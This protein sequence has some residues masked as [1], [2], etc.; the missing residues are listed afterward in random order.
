VLVLIGAAGA[1]ALLWWFFFGPKRSST[2]EL[3]GGVQEIH[4]TVKGGYSP[5]R[6]RARRGVPLRVIFDRQ[7]TGDCTARVV[8]PD[9]AMSRSLPAYA[10]TAVELTPDRV[11]EFGFACG[12]NMVHGTLV[13][14][15]TDH[16]PE[17][18]G[19]GAGSNGAHDE[20]APTPD[21]VE[22]PDAVTARGAHEI[23]DAEAAARR[24]EIADLSRRVLV[25][26]LLTAP[27]AFAAM[28]HDLFGATWVPD[29]LLDRWVQL[30]LIT[31]VMLYT[32]WPIHHIGWLT[33]RHRTAEMNTLITLGT[34]AAYSY[35]LLVTIAPSV[36]PGDVREVY[37]ETVGV[38]L[39]LI[40]LGRL[41]ETRAK[42]GTGEAIR[43]LIGLQART[44]RVIRDNVEV[45][46]PIDEVAG[47][48]VVV[49]RPGEKIPV[50]GTVIDGTSTVDESMVTG[51]PIPVT[52]RTDDTVIGATI[53]QTGAFRMRA[54]KVGAET[55][56][57]QIIKLV[58]AA[59][60]SKAPIQ[61]LADRV[62]SYF[63]PAVMVIAVWTFAIWYLTGPDPVL[64]L[65]LVTAVAVLIIACPC[66][67]G[68]ATPLSIMVGTGIGATQGILIRSAEALETAEKLDTLIL[69]KTGTITRGQPALTDVI[70]DGF[71]E[72]ELLELVASAEHSSEHPLAEAIV[73]GA[74]A[75]GLELTDPS[76]FQ[77]VTGQGISGRVQGR[78]VLI[79]NRRLLETEGIPANALEPHAERLANEGKTPMLV[80][81]DGTAAGVIAVADTLK[82]DSVLAIRA[83]QDLNL[84]VVMIT[85][86]NRRTAAAIAK[87]VGITRV[88]AE[89]L[90]E[91]KALEVRRLQGEGRTVGMVG[92]GINDAPALAQ[93]DVGAA[94][95]TGT[96]VAI[97]SSDV[98]LV[99]GALGGLVTAI[100]LSRATMRNI[101][102]N[103]FLAFVYNTIGIPLAAGALYPLFEL[104][105]SPI[106]AATAMALSSLSVVTNANRLHRFTPTTPSSSA[107]PHP[108]DPLV[109]VSDT[110]ETDMATTDPV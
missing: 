68:L 20:R 55:L 14:E 104:R 21:A 100:Q 5:D 16:G 78:A 8:F 50:D 64:T 63:V 62:S 87:Q 56:L 45:E 106:V 24:A 89:V 103:L 84:D 75:R 31:P 74:R 97:E 101:R 67:L 82:D 57:A 80:A 77:S 90:P 76:E 27:V 25:G 18:G 11:G 73:A 46:I 72:P 51:E 86:D 49:V 9:F 59:Q 65:S 91:H 83:L 79:G 85:G 22:H 58:E 61:R 13:I 23:E 36:F 66:A 108:V 69:D 93:A 88:L 33:L 30:A 47:G 32:G 15:D 35:S 52:K 102:Q 99:S 17:R 48:D 4:V 34:V 40:L 53:N 71:D 19:V 29:V 81:I 110:I 105:L 41:F 6:I 12:M 38:I 70:A 98:T 43:K 2:A 7:E 107:T 94:I 39:T 109:E 1:S 10:T 26:A 60:A 95:G 37:F 96:D 92:D 28:A 54:D 44:A 3:R 42:A